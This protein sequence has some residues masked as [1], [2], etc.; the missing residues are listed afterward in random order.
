MKSKYL[1]L[2]FFAL[3]ISAFAAKQPVLAYTFECK[4]GT[5]QGEGPCSQGGRPGA[6][7]L[8]SD[9]NFYGTAQVSA[10]GSSTPSGGTVFSVTPSG[11]FTLLHTFLPGAGNDYPEG[12]V[13]GLLV[14]G[15]DGKIYGTTLFGGIG[16][17]TDA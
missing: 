14:E 17:P 9:G 8:G 3:T 4:N 10:E 7:I 15:A 2:V 16:G 1:L 12:N 11:K 13:P 5:F 6:L